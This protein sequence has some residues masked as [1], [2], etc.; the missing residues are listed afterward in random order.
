MKGDSIRVTARVHPEPPQ[1]SE[2]VFRLAGVDSLRFRDTELDSLVVPVVGD[3]ASAKLW[4]Y[5]YWG[6]ASL[7]ATHRGLEGEASDAGEIPIDADDDGIADSWEMSP[8]GGGT[9]EHGGNDQDQDWDEETSQGTT[10]DGDKFTK[11][12]EYK[13]IMITPVVNPDS[14]V[15]RRLRADRK[16]F[17]VLVDS[18]LAV[19]VD[20]AVVEIGQQL[21]IDAI[22]Y[23]FSKELVQVFG[24]PAFQSSIVRVIDED[25]EHA[26]LDGLVWDAG[27]HQGD[28]TVTVG[29]TNGALWMN[30]S[31]VPV[32]IY[33]EA[34][35]NF[36]QA[37]SYPEESTTQPEFIPWWV[38]ESLLDRVWLAYFNNKSVNGDKDTDDLIN[39]FDLLAPPP[40]HGPFRNDDYDGEIASFME[41]VFLR[42]VILHE[43]GH[44]LGMRH[45]NEYEVPLYASPMRQ[46]VGPG[47]TKMF[48]LSDKERVWIRY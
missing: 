43:L 37:N 17:L 39:P 5:A 32:E 47:K 15:Y 38:T 31:G 46:G 35:Q 40:D 24:R 34:I 42:R 30:A 48:D 6:V 14:A 20:S 45:P 21:E 12:A 3:S 29:W 11:E 2:V 44:A 33:S 25:Y 22:A 26:L 13:G 16:E 41:G 8:E 7:T 23:T 18:V 4:S 10:H 36:W 19:H 27:V 28:T 1:G 9:M